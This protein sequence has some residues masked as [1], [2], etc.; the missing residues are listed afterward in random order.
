[1]KKT[2]IYLLSFLFLNT[3]CNFLDVVPDNVATIDHAFA[4]ETTAER[5][6]LTCYGGLPSEGSI[7]SNPAFLAGDEFWSWNQFIGY[8]EESSLCNPWRI[9]RGTQNSNDPWL[10][11]YEGRNNGKALF[12]TIRKCNIFL[13]NISKVNGLSN[14]NYSKWTA[15]ARFIK[16]Y[17]HFYLL[18]M[19]GPIPLIKQNLPVSASPEEV[20]YARNTFD[21]CIDYITSELT[22]IAS[23]L[24][25]KVLNTQEELGRITEPI[26]L[27]LKAK[28]LILAASPLF[29]GNPYYADLRTPSGTPLFSSENPEKWLLAKNACKEAIESCH[30][31]GMSLHKY[32]GLVGMD[33]KVKLDYT[34]RTSVTDETWNNELIWGAVVGTGNGIQKY[35]Q[36]Y[37]E[38]TM[39][40][41]GHIHLVLAVNMKIAKQ[42]YTSNGVPIN[43][44]KS[45]IDKNIY[46]LRTAKDEE[47]IYIKGR[48]AQLNFDREPRFYSSLGFDRGVWYGNG[49]NIDAPWV[50]QGLFKQAS[51]RTG[52]S[53]RGNVTGYFAKKLINEKSTMRAPDIYSAKNYPF[54]IFRL[55]DLYLLYAEASN[56]VNGPT[57][58]T[59]EYLDKVRER[60]GLENTLSSWKAHS[61]NP[62]KPTT[63][64][65][66]RE[67]IREERL[68]ELA[69]E[70]HRFWDLKRWLLSE[71]YLNEAVTGWNVTQE[72][73]EDYYSETVLFNQSFYPKEYLWPIRQYSLTINKNMTQAKGW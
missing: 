56:E 19:Y 3:A 46:E 59:F 57:Q 53:E 18:R 7:G 41:G 14:Y 58:E 52:N 72:Q 32:Y 42:F 39:N 8:S 30:K 66:L 26:A 67:I 5:Y 62:S 13:E 60:A 21:E 49:K 6:L 51:N 23:Y 17:C 27:T 34:L 22:E 43:E 70:G 64:N 28:V 16:A 25:S 35:A 55:A 1:M 50:L 9:A 10:N 20:Q 69:L 33:D 68:N 47:E 29:N 61:T 38:P 40:I 73:A 37:L 54:P 12:Q 15:E 65:G 4:D 11:Y 2:T 63:Q 48:T 71:I 44:D 31:A 36:P 45:W 24:P